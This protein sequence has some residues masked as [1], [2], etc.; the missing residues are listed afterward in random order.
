MKPTLT[1][2]IDPGLVNTGAVSMLFVPEAR[3]IV[4]SSFVQ[5]GPKARPVANWLREQ[6][7]GSLVGPAHTFVEQ[8]RPRI[9]YAQDTRMV[10]AQQDFRSELPR[11]KFINNTG[12]KKIV[13]R[14][15]MELLGVWQ[16]HIPTHHQD[17]R[18]AARIA[19]FGML[20]DDEL[21][22]VVTT[23]VKDHLDGRTW[24]VESR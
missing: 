10:E 8:Y 4:V 2:G 7:P 13:K 6:R 16:F 20:K 18:S 11:A 23:V 12:S 24:H 9:G 5:V 3:K 14:Q 19:V 15:L 22:A 21:N 1:E 17:L